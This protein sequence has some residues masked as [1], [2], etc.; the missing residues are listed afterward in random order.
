MSAASQN[1]IGARAAAS[2]EEVAA[3]MEWET[4]HN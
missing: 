2:G 4:L 1:Q 3:I